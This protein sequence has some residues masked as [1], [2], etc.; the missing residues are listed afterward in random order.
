MGLHFNHSLLSLPTNVRLNGSSK[1]FG[2]Y[3]M[4]TIKSVKGFMEEELVVLSTT[5]GS[6]GSTKANKQIQPNLV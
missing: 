3:D 2:F 1:H 6:L 4:A 5:L